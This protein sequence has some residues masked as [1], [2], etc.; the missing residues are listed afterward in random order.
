LKALGL[1]LRP[2]IDHLVMGAADLEQGCRQVSERLGVPLAPGGRH[3]HMGT[4]NRLL[5]L[6]Q[7]CYLEVIAI[8]PE[9]PPPGRPRWF[10]LD[11]PET[12][13]RLAEEPRL[14]TWV[15]HGIPFAGLDPSLAHHLGRPEPMRR[16]DLRW[17]LTLHADGH[18]PAGGLLPG[19]IEWDG[20]HHPAQ[21]LPDAGCRLTRIRL[22]PTAPDTLSTLLQAI[23]C[24]HM[25]DLVFRESAQTSCLTAEIETPEGPRHLTSLPDPSRS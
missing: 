17:R 16:G 2:G 25:I 1:D 19:L 7:A 13:A 8:D 24:R 3:A 20:P 22:S 6:G 10:G 18:L 5:K 12:T 9:A 21:R 4:H 15:V 14:L 23:G 11:R